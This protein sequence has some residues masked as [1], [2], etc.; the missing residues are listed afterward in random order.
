MTEGVRR[1]THE[2]AEMLI[3]ARMDEQLDRADS[4]ALLV[5]LQSC[6]SCRAFAVQSEVLGR[7]LA[8]LP[9]LPPSAV[10]DRQIRESIARGERRWSFA[11]LFPGTAG[12]SGMRAA[13]GA[14]AVLALVSVFLLL[15]MADNR[16]STGGSI[17]APSGGVA[18]QLDTTPTA[19]LAMLPVTAVSGPTET[20]RLVV[21]KTQAAGA[22]ESAP[23]QNA[24]VSTAYPTQIEP[25]STLDSS[26]VYAIDQSTQT[27][28]VGGPMPTKTPASAQP[29]VTPADGQVVAAAAAPGAGTP[30]GG[31]MELSPVSNSA[32]AAQGDQPATATV[33]SEVPVQQTPTLSPTATPPPTMTPAPVEISVGVTEQPQGS[34]TPQAES[35]TGDITSPITSSPADA[36]AGG[37]ETPIQVAQPDTPPA[38]VE[39]P[40]GQPT[41]AP[42]AGQSATDTGA[43]S[44]PTSPAIVPNNGSAVE[45][46]ST[47]GDSPAIVSTSGEGTPAGVGGDTNPGHAGTSSPEAIP[48]VDQSTAPSGL[49]LSDTV[50]QLPAGTSSPLGRLEFSPGMDLYAV[51]AP[52]GQL[53]VANLD[54]ELVV[55]LGQGDLP[56]WSGND[57][58]FRSPGD[59]GSVVGIWDSESGHIDYIAASEDEPSNDLPIGGNGSTLYYLRTFPDRPGAMEIRSAATDGSDQESVWASDSTTLG[60]ARPAWSDAG[61]LLPTDSSWLLIDPNGDASDLGENPYG[62]VGVPVVSPGGG[63]MAYSAGD[64][65]IVAW[66]DTPGTPVATAPFGRSTGGYAFSSSGEQVVVSDGAVLHIVSY[67]GEDLGSL[68]GNQPI[69]G[70]YWISDTIYY[71]QIGQNAA[72]KSTSQDAMQSH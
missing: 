13:F 26:F 39:E 57:L 17:A 3:S 64:Q 22:A 53:A 63:L 32:N 24:V 34:A 4:R 41:I 52:D 38:T 23:T 30:A 49:D 27:P 50:A 25:T 65:V 9:V 72:L 35:S 5:H 37:G 46:A 47:G 61:I 70:V 29:A 55:T 20:P 36:H 42:M 40:L 66:T 56:V 14:L 44:A 62:S 54:G 43:S 16:T 7:E 15:R 58:L 31:P 33:G 1:L 10:V 59:S 69:G 71:L 67:Q 21:P 12:N 11:S 60:G 68:G 2:E 48:V 28:G 18:Q 45:A 8:A 19:E 6:E 51:I